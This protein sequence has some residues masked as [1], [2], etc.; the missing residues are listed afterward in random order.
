MPFVSVVIPTHNRASF[1]EE[2]ASSVLEQTF[3]DLELIIVDDASTDGTANILDRLAD[4]D[5]RVRIIRR[6]T[7]S[8]GPA[9]PRNEGI[10]MATGEMISFLDDDDRWHP[11]RVAL[12]LEGLMRTSTGSR[13]STTFEK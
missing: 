7:S 13:H 9:V 4:Q 11:E 5:R 8:G 10:G 12:T 1:L 6:E 2:A 3:D